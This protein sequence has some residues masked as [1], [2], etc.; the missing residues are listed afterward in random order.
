[1]T[2]L[3]ILIFLLPAAIAIGF[4]VWPI[5]RPRKGSLASRIVL[6]AAASAF[7]LGVGGGL[8][9]YL[10]RPALAL[11]TLT[12]PRAD[13]FNSL[14]TTLAWHVRERPA[15]LRAW[16]LLWPSYLRLDDPRD[17]A[18]AFRREVAIA[19]A[20]LRS[21]LYST[22]GEELSAAAGGITEDAEAAFKAALALDPKDLK[23]RYYMG[24]DYAARGDNARAI[25]IWEN[26]L[27]D[28]PANT[29]IHG[30]L[31]DRIAALKSRNGAAPNVAAMVENL[32]NRLKSNPDDPEGWQRLV[33]AYA[34]LG[35][36]AKARAA[37]ADARVALRAE[38]AAS[39]ALAAEAKELKLE[40]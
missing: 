11:R 40:K 19:P 31:V 17:A 26:L 20:E 10:G 35:D 2:A 6:A 12:G 24:F 34:V 32:A 36:S 39:A 33:R 38:P 13:D 4:V 3:L 27:S 30:V 8:Y 15:D 18:A 22:Y 1:M 5:L 14:V 25:A 9:L 37:L 28:L 29:R 23:A 16:A 7:L 21:G